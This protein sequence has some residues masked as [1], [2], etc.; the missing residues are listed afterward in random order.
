MATFRET[1]AHSVYRTFSLYFDMVILTIS[2][3]FRAV[4]VLIASVPGHCLSFISYNK[5][6]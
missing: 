5:T 4:L 6:E 2:H 1:A 3:V